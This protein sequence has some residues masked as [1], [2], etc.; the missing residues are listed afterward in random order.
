M[1]TYK[2]HALDEFVK[3]ALQHFPGQV[4]RVGGRSSDEQIEKINLRN[5]KREGKKCYDFIDVKNS[6]YEEIDVLRG[7][8]E[9][10]FDRLDESTVLSYR[11]FVFSIPASEPSEL[12]WAHHFS[13]FLD[14]MSIHVNLSLLYDRELNHFHI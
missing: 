10:S 13:L 8:I 3:S 7:G 9:D 5:V 14:L 11:Y 6:L 1:L 4:V 12:F 2:N